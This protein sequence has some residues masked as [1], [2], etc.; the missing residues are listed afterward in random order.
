[1]KIRTVSIAVLAA[2]A[3]TAPMLAA[4]QP[5][6]V[7]VPLLVSRTGP[8]AP[9]GIPIADGFVDYFAHIKDAEIARFQMEVT[10]WEHREYFDLF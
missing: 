8:Y 10:E 2:L 9:S 7:F 3:I 5:K 6:E 1:M 4:A